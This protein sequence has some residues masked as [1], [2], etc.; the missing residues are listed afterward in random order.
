MACD[1][2]F[3]PTFSRRYLYIHRK[4]YETFFRDDKTEFQSFVDPDLLITSFFKEPIW[5]MLLSNKAILPILWELF[6]NHPNLLPA[7]FTEEE[8]K[9]HLS[10]VGYVKKP[11]FG[12]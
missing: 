4:S 2:G 7:Y 6:P 1:G 11:I 10:D 9:H 12:K 8:A 5:K 3:Q